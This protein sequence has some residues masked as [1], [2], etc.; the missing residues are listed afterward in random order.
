MISCECII[1]YGL[2]QV[3]CCVKDTHDYKQAEAESMVMAITTVPEKHDEDF[4]GY[5]ITS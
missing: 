5:Y 4:F 2:R 3:P 1:A